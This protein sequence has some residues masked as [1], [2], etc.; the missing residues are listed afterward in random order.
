MQNK[1][2]F[3]FGYEGNKRNEIKEINNVINNYD[4]EYIV[5]PYCGSCA[6]S[7]FLSVQYPKKYK[8][9]LND[10]DDN[11]INL[12]KLLSN[13]DK[14]EEFER[15][16]NDICSNENF[17][18][19]IYKNLDGLEGY[20]IRHKIYSIRAGLFR[21]NYKYKY[22][23]IKNCKFINFLMTENITLLNQEGLEIYQEYKNKNSIIF[24][25]PPYLLA[26]NSCYKNPA[27][28][29]YEYLYDNKIKK[30]KAII[31]I[32]VE[33]NFLIKI[34]FKKYK[35]HLYNKCNIKNRR[36]FKQ[37]LVICNK[38]LI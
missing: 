6:F 19:E 38:N 9:I 37:H 29:I 26:D 32:T 18:K 2:H 33:Y 21:I 10:N 34:L 15:K 36:Q 17:N 3:I 27:L 5:E 23:D 35:F 16:I 24:L 25:D 31:I 30:E 11:L 7:F 8:Y 14:L 4:V 22:I 20:Y 12:L 1:N 28:K 13:M